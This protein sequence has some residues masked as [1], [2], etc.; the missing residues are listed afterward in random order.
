MPRF[1]YVALD[2]RG[3]E[4]TGLV[5][6]NTANE[7]IGHLRQAGYFPTG[8]HEE[9]KAPATNRKAKRAKTSA[10]PAQVPTKAKRGLNMEITVFQRK[11]V[12]GKVLMIFTRQLATL[13]DSGLPL[14]RSLNVL[15][16]QEKDAVLK[17]T[18]EALADSVQGGNTFSDSLAR[19]RKI[20]NELYISMVKA[21]ELGGV[22]EVVLS[23][24]AE[25]QEKE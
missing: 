2:G 16:K 11:T 17:K 13:I 19:H 1:Q 5:D 22:L 12:K 25:F 8:V 21:G 3:Q 10:I 24:L 20:F 4:S 7:A 15:A 18:T 14:L 23:R 9:G 6:A